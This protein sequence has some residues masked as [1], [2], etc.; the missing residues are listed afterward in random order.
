M[1][2]ILLDIEGTTTPIDFVQKTLFPFARLRMPAYVAN[3]FEELDHEI[4]LLRIEHEKDLGYTEDFDPH[5]AKSVAKYLMFLIDA[6]REMLFCSDVVGELSAARLEGF[7]T[8]LVLRK[9][10]AEITEDVT[11]RAIESLDELE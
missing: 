10:N 11:H 4:N 9:G 2:A 5:V 1:K 8:A 6:D 3:H 7:Q